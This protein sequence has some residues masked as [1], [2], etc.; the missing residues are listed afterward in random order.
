MITISIPATQELANHFAKKAPR[1]I[2]IYLEDTGCSS[3]QL[4]LAGDEVRDGDKVVEQGGFTL[5]IN[6]ELSEAVGTVSI[7]SAQY[8][9]IIS[10]EKPIAGGGGCS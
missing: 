10:S 2:R 8:G 6:K 4:A 9:F 1:P 3:M 7:D 5:V